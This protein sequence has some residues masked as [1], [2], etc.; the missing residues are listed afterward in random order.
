MIHFIIHSA[1]LLAKRENRPF[2]YHVKKGLK[3]QLQQRLHDE[4]HFLDNLLKC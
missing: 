1:K 2:K 3:T 4:S